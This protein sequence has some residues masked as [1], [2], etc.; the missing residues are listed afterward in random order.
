[1]VFRGR[2][3]ATASEQ[4]AH[5][6]VAPTYQS[7]CRRLTS[8]L[9]IVRD[10]AHGNCRRF[11]HESNSLVSSNILG[12]C[13]SLY[14]SCFAIDSSSLRG[15]YEKDSN[16]LGELAMF[17]R[18]HF[19]VAADNTASSNVRPGLTSYENIRLGMIEC[20]HSAG[21]VMGLTLR[22]SNGVSFVSL[23]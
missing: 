12:V 22:V 7:S 13:K 6:T 8:S 5:R 1:M 15:A 21:A 23:L 10:G 4:H 18:S 3:L 9:D 2:D 11:M 20:R 16:Y 19:I 14:C 17:Q